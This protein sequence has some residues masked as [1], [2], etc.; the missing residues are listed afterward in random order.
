M[1]EEE[2]QSELAEFL[3]S[4]RARVSPADLELPTAGRRRAS[5]LRREEVAWLAGISADYYARLEQARVAR[6]SAAIL[7]SLARVL[8]LSDDERSYL[9]R[10]GGISGQ[11]PVAMC[12]EV[13]PGILRLLM[14][15]TNIPAHVL[16]ATYEVLV[17]NPLGQA[18][19]FGAFS[20]PPAQPNGLRAIFLNPNPRLHPADWEEVA[21]ATVA[22]LRVTAARYPDDPGVHALVDELLAASPKFAHLWSE[23]EVAVRASGHYRILHPDVGLLDLD[24]EMVHLHDRDQRLMLYSAE[25]GSPSF[26]RL[27]ELDRKV[28][29][30]TA[31]NISK[32]TA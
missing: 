18:V 25:S 12:R 11:L 19:M 3:R 4:R 22:D 27:L 10:I 13:A 28:R 24:Y 16:D 23:H 2:R 5:G 7:A 14:R 17:S 29:D 8:G 26:E 20:T 30:R 31:D 6:P 9:F 15:L 21:R 32:A 1:V